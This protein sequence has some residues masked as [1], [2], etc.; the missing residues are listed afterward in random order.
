MSALVAGDGGI[1]AMWFYLA[2]YA[3][4]LVG[5]FTVAAV[6]SGPRADRSPFETYQGLASRSPLL[7]ALLAL[8][9]LGLAGFPLTAGFV[10]K[11]SVF[12]AAASAG[13]L[14]LAVLALVVAVA[15]LFFYLRVIVLMYFTEP[16][17]AEAPGTAT[18][19]PQV[20]GPARVVLGVAA[21]VTL[22]L[23]LV[24]WPLLELVGN[25]LPL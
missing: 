13:Y 14:W 19:S 5:A 15:G 17:L 3:V 24:P 7:A 16:A 4:A 1:P 11:V 8:F 18:A 20:D 21:A 12:S 9:M 22:G 10:G 2:T 6:V 23:G 25:A